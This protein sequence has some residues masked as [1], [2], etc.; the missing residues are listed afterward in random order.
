MVFYAP[1]ITTFWYAGVFGGIREYSVEAFGQRIFGR[2]VFGGGI[3]TEG[4][5]TEGIRWRYSVM[6]FGRTQPKY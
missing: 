2:R 3:R 5:R 1:Q 6:V 4:I